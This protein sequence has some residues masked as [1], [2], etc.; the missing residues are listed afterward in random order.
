VAYKRP[1][2]VRGRSAHRRKNP[3]DTLMGAAIAVGVGVL[4]SVAASY[5]LDTLSTSVTSLQSSTYQDGVLLVGAGAAAYWVKNPAIAAGI[6]TGLLLIPAAK[7]VYS[8]FPSLASANTYNPQNPSVTMTSLHA[9]MSSLHRP[10]GSLH[11]PMGAVFD[12]GE[13]SSPFNAFGDDMGALN[14]GSAMFSRHV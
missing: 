5:L 12:L 6:A 14:R 8:V 1:F 13:G 3:S 4:T 2:H 10:M 7:L 9:P 11:R